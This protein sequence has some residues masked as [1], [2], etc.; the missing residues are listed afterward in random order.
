MFSRFSLE[1][2]KAKALF[3][4]YFTLL[5]V[6]PF[7]LGNRVDGGASG[8]DGN[9]IATSALFIDQASF[10]GRG[11]P[12]GSIARAVYSDTQNSI[13]ITDQTNENISLYI[14]DVNGWNGT[15]VNASISNIRD[16]RDWVVGGSYNDSVIDPVVNTNLVINQQV[17]NYN[18]P[19]STYFASMAWIDSYQLYENE[20][21]RAMKVHFEQVN[22]DGPQDT[23]T[24]YDGD[25]NLL[26][27]YSSSLT[28]FNT[29]WFEPSGFYI[30]YESDNNNEMENLFVIDKIY[31]IPV[32]GSV[33]VTAETTH[34]YPANLDGSSGDIITSSAPETVYMRA[35]FSQ[36]EIEGDGYDYVT[37]YDNTSTSAFTYDTGASMYSDEWLSWVQSDEISINLTSDGVDQYWGYQVDKYQWSTIGSADFD[38]NAREL[39]ISIRWNHYKDDQILGS[40]NYTVNC[41]GATHMRLN[42]SHVNFQEGYDYLVLHDNES[43]YLM[44]YTGYFDNVVTPW[45]KTDS[46]DLSYLS[47]GSWRGEV[48]YNPGYWIDHADWIDYAALNISNRTDDWTFSYSYDIESGRASGYGAERDGEIGMALDLQAVNET[49]SGATYSW[50][51][52]SYE[53]SDAAEFNQLVAIDRGQVIDGYVKLDYYGDKCMPSGDL[54]LY[55][56]INDTVVYTRGFNTISQVPRQ[57]QSTGKIWMGIW[58]NTTNLFDAISGNADIKLSV[59]I[60]YDYDGSIIYS[61]FEHRERQIVV[62]DDVEFVL[63]TRANATQS[64]INLQ[65]NGVPVSDGSSWGEGEYI[66]TG[67]WV[68]DPLNL[69]FTTSSPDLEFDAICTLDVQTSFNSTYSQSTA[70]EG[71]NSLGN[72]NDDIS[73]QFF[74]NVYLPAGYSNYNLT[75]QIPGSWQ[76]DSITGP[77]GGNQP[78]QFGNL[79]DGSFQFSTNAP[80]WYDVAASSQNYLNRTHFSVDN[81]TWY[82]SLLINDSDVL[83]LA[84]TFNKTMSPPNGNVT[85]EIFYPN[86]TSW[87]LVETTLATPDNITF[88]PITY[89]PSNTTGGVYSG[90]V[91]WENGTDVGYVNFT[92][93]CVH[94]SRIAVQYPVDAIATNYTVQRVDSIVPLRVSFEDKFT[95]GYIGRAS[96]SASL[97]DTPAV[98]FNFVESSSGIY[99]YSLNT[100]GLTGG[101]YLI[102]INATKPGYDDAFLDITLELSVETQIENFVSFH[103]V[104]Q[105][106]NVT[107]SLD[108][109]AQASGTGISGATIAASFSSLD[110][111]IQDHANGTYSILVNTTGLD[112]GSQPYNLTIGKPYFDNKTVS[113]IL[114]IVERR[115]S[116]DC[117]NGTIPGTLDEDIGPFVFDFYHPDYPATVKYDDSNLT[118]FMDAA[119]LVPMDPTNYTVNNLGGGS[120]SI[121]LHTGTGT[122]LG[123]AGSWD[124]YILGRNASTSPYHVSDDTISISFILEKRQVSFS[125]FYNTT[126]ITGGASVTLGSENDML[127]NVSATDILSS[128]FALDYAVIYNVSNGHNGVLNL[129]GN[130]YTAVISHNDLSDGSFVL[131]ITG[132]S[133]IHDTIA[134]EYF[135]VVQPIVTYVE[136]FSSFFQEEHGFDVNIS[137]HY[138]DAT[139]DLGVVG[140]SVNFSLS[141]V[142][143]VDPSN[144]TFVDHLDGNYSIIMNTSVVQTGT[145]DITIDVGKQYHASVVLNGNLDILPRRSQLDLYNTTVSGYL[146]DEIGPIEMYFYHPDYP[147]VMNYTGATFTLYSDSQKQHLIDPS[148][149]TIQAGGDGMYTINISTGL[150]TWLNDSGLFDLYIVG[151]NSSSYSC[152]IANDTATLSISIDTRPVTYTIFYNA[153]DITSDATISLGTI[154]DL[155]LNISIEDTST[156]SPALDYQVTLNISN[157]HEDNFTLVANQYSVFVDNGALSEGVYVLTISCSSDI[158]DSFDVQYFLNVQPIATYTQGFENYYQVEHGIDVNV[159]FHYHDATN[160]VGIAGANANLTLSGIGLINPADYV[161]VDLLNG[162]YSIIINSSLYTPAQRDMSITVGKPFHATV[163]MN[164]TLEIIA[165]KSQLDV[166][167]TSITGYL[168]DEITPITLLFYHPDYPGVVNYTDSVFTLYYDASFSV[169]VDPSNYTIVPGADDTYILSIKTGAGTAFNDSGIKELY[170]MAGNS[171][172][173]PWHVANDTAFLTFVLSKRPM[174]YSIFLNDVDITNDTG[175]SF[176]TKQTTILN[177]TITDE[178]NGSTATITLDYNVTGGPAGS[179]A[180]VGNN[181]T[182]DIASGNYTTG[183]HELSIYSQS[184]YY[185][186][187]SFLYFINIIPLEMGLNLTIN[188]TCVHAGNRYDAFLGDVLGMTSVVFDKEANST[189]GAGTIELSVDGVPLNNFT[190]NGSAYVLPLDTWV[191]SSG[192]HSLSLFVSMP[193]YTSLFHSFT[194]Q[195]EKRTLNTNVTLNG[196]AWDGI[197]IVEFNFTDQV[198]LEIQGIDSM[199]LSIIPTS[200]LGLILPSEIS[201][202]INVSSANTHAINFNTTILGI[203]RHIL[204]F[205]LEGDN[206]QSLAFN[207]VMDVNP[208][209]MVIALQ[210]NQTVITG[211]PGESVS[212]III[213]QAADGSPIAGANVSYTWAG[214][215]DFLVDQGGG[216]YII[217]IELPR[218]EGIHD[219][220]IQAYYNANYSVSTFE[221]TLSIQKAPLS[222]ASIIVTI[223]IIGGFLL[224]LF[225]MGY[226]MY[227][228][229]KIIKRRLTKFEDVKTCTVH[230]GPI[231]DGLTYVCPTCGNIYCTKCAQALYNNNDACWSCKTPIQPFAVSYLDDWR[232]NLQHLMLFLNG[233][234]TP[235]HEISLSKED[236]MVPEVFSLLKKNIAEQIKKIE[237]SKKTMVVQEYFNSKILYCRGQF[238][239][240]VIISRIDSSFIRD[241]MQDFIE[242]FEIIFYDPSKKTWREQMRNKFTTKTNLLIDKMFLKEEKPDAE[243]KGKKGKGKG[244]GDSGYVD[245]ADSVHK[246]TSD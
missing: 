91:A 99:D 205:Q 194:L 79:G 131:S 199:S 196:S 225:L 18:Y 120:Y 14:D 167:N 87:D 51:D 219:M 9:F 3:L 160:D 57:W 45:F 78:Y 213:L 165:R 23:I 237:K 41:P 130:Y 183:I 193:N 182:V 27:T 88:S 229:P 17:V 16:T 139:N 95:G 15:K 144:Y 223:S 177:I 214:G 241:K 108:Y 200:E 132:T 159:S 35:H 38:A 73:W 5:L 192:F 60:R 7:L 138:H 69:T 25:L 133:A 107:I 246:G 161:F 40:E 46:I 191:V 96:V 184:I 22:V 65:V 82:D 52:F 90:Y 118:V 126:N 76:I 56:A 226:F 238:V 244:K 218:T 227:L 31:Y 112:L 228:R 211:E 146:L 147:G 39:N 208:L 151:T 134:K 72:A 113:G 245:A 105:G 166:V 4:I 43:N 128:N 135:L 140:A 117:L 66:A 124:L 26:D 59:G 49:D 74:E 243:G 98:N 109:K 233:S 61:G 153:T 44:D 62:I 240:L 48:N 235:I 180:L 187:I 188:G 19:N 168:P 125:I 85:M 149:Y 221:F 224:I 106:F 162:N 176:S 37:V 212:I 92:V 222:P 1:N 175:F 86:G 204:A 83:F 34:P 157:G 115:S 155:Q 30:G 71:V 136:G 122:A 173:S 198:S 70:N 101:Y 163:V 114:S 36:V 143:L 172:A 181:Y 156:A 29:S 158:H 28:D 217:S 220:E 197:S 47:D 54:Q 129:Q 201:T 6:S 33:P 178:V 231:T 100:S 170:I 236:V 239:T 24:I 111:T 42:F 75:V 53:S 103:E 123:T 97:N 234:A 171:S 209:P 10:Q 32:N 148:N 195:V 80:G 154:N 169:T 110:Y 174:N 186:P 67:N 84:A 164:G 185:E 137:F 104:E 21:M 77:S 11:D 94:S 8:V 202:F 20:S 179:F 68:V 242:E 64:G 50:E 210:G 89:G 216:V 55:V 207:L 189:L 116:L 121:I 102:R 190:Y 63:V 58:Q 150:T 206:Y 81:S 203:G 119:L 142:G 215:F 13:S 232:S 141:G 12:R 145:Y 230:K 127:L 152:E 93:D 2:K